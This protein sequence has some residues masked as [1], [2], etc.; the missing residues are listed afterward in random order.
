VFPAPD[1][2][3][4]AVRWND[5]TEAGLVLVE[6]LREPSQLGAAWD[7]RETNWLEGPVWTPDSELVVLVENPQGAGPW[8]AEREPG[9]ADDDE[10][11]LG[12]AFTPGSVVVLGR[13]LRERFRR[14]IEV[15]V[16]PNWFPAGDA[17][18]GLGAPKIVS[19]EGVVLRVPTEG[20]R[21]FT[22]HDR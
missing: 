10:V 5:Q 11:S 1:G 12:G 3:L 14:R 15:D 4:A 20:K 16:P 22:L 19:P 18:R 8:W 13:D 17:E 9:E 7:T 21:R 2:S 6:L